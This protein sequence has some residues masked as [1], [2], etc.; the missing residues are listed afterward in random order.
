[1]CAPRH[2]IDKTRQTRHLEN[3]N[4][5]CNV[6]F[7]LSTSSMDPKYHSHFQVINIEVLS[8]ESK[9]GILITPI[10]FS[11]IRVNLARLH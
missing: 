1:M 7:M 5:L 9:Q 10:F 3:G 4:V 6:L 11:A 2:Q 8:E